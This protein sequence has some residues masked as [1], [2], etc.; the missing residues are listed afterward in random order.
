M[1]LL[2]TAFVGALL[3]GGC[4][5][6]IYRWVDEDGKVH[7]GSAP[8]PEVITKAEETKVFS[9]APRESINAKD[10]IYG[11]WIGRHN[12][13]IIELDIPRGGQ[14]VWRE[15]REQGY[16]LRG[17]SISSFS[18]RPLISGN[19]MKIT[20]QRRGSE[21]KQD[22]EFE[23]R[24]S[25]SEK[26]T[27]VNLSDGEVYQFFKNPRETRPLKAEEREIE[28]DWARVDHADGN[29]VTG[30][31]RLGGG[32]F[33]QHRPS[34]ADRI[35]SKPSDGL[36]DANGHW[37]V[38]GDILHLEYR[39][40]QREY[41]SKMFGSDQWRIEE[42]DPRKLVLINTKK[43]EIMVFRRERTR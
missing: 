27:L 34:S 13:K 30:W 16:T 5:S 4:G 36:M 31:L 32:I 24:P 35:T 10:M 26:V 1:K 38:E 17:G 22:L 41:A 14:L 19:R 11:L 3:V 43:K 40:G 6:D 8:P 15:A 2:R 29:K 33:S 21:E 9:S 25:D 20:A 7:F 39:L 28:G 23:I 37:R 42:V 12:G 18:G